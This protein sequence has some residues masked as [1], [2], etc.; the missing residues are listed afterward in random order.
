LPFPQCLIILYGNQYGIGGGSMSKIKSALELALEK[1][2]SIPSDKGQYEKELA[3]KEGRMALVKALA[4]E[5]DPLD[6]F[7]DLALKQTANIRENFVEGGFSAL[8]DQLNLPEKPEKNAEIEKITPLIGGF[9]KDKSSTDE[10]MHQLTGFLAQYASNIDAVKKRIEEQFAPKL[11]AKEDEIAQ[12]TGNKIKLSIYQDQEAAGYL[13]QTLSQL[14][15]RYQQA[16]SEAKEELR[17]MFEKNKA[18]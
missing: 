13:T 18:F 11:R 17:S 4:S 12:K 2:A 8:L 6:F 14:K 7:R 1:T 16:L 3:G 15:S 9:I 5:K 10:L